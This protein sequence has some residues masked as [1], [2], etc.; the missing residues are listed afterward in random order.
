MPKCKNDSSRSYK[1]TEP[2]PKGLG[3]CG[4][5]EKVGKRMKGKDGKIWIVVKNKNGIKKWTRFKRSS[6]SES[7]KDF[8]LGTKRKGG[9]GN[10]WIITKN[11][12]G[13]KKWT[14]INPKKKTSKKKVEKDIY[15]TI[16]RERKKA[17]NSNDLLVLDLLKDQIKAQ[18]KNY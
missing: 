7:A 2:S 18:M 3:Y 6:P 1:G 10:K 13:V 16:D 9:D 17:K 11:K 15:D 8:K 5:A 12:N 14:K 4:H